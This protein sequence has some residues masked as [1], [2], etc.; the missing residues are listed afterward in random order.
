[1]A[2]KKKKSELTARAPRKAAPTKSAKSENVR[3]RSASPG[4]TVNDIEK[5]VAWYRDVL[6]FAVKERWEEKGKLLGVEMMAGDVIFMLG[7]D[8]WKKGRNRLKG[9]GVRIYCST[10]QNVD[11]IAER[12]KANGGTLLQEPRD[13]PWGMRD[14]AV[15]DPDGFKITVAFDSKP[16]R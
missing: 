8:D 12:I 2:T 3:L 6:G 10:D 13:Q 5:S 7:Q 11:R 15:E 16:K 4:F 1:M 9:E 14:F